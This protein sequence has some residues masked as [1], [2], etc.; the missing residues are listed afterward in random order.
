MKSFR[1]YI[2]F[3]IIAFL[4]EIIVFNPF[5]FLNLS[6]KGSS[7]SI[8]GNFSI[9]SGQS[10][11]SASLSDCNINCE[12]IY[13]DLS[14]VMENGEQSPVDVTV[15]L[16]DDGNSIPYTLS[17][18][19]IFPGIKKERYLTI[20]PYGNVHSLDISIASQY[21][22]S[23]QVNDVVVNPRT[24]LFFRLPRFLFVALLL[25]LTDLFLLKNPIWKKEWSKSEAIISTAIVLFI[26]I[27]F[28][29]VLARMGKAFL[30]P[31][32]DYHFQY[33][34][35]ARAI[36]E[37]KLYIN[38]DYTDI[39]VS[40]QSIPNPY[41]TVMRSSLADVSNCWDIAYFNGHFYVYFGV[42][43]VF[44][45][46]LPYYLIFHKDFPTWFGV[47]ISASMALC[48]SFYLFYVI[49]KK[50]FASLS[51][52]QY[53]VLSI[54]L[55]NS[56]NLFV[57][58][59]HADFYYL[60]IVT[61]LAFVL[62][63]LGLIMHATYFNN[64]KVVVRGLRYALGSLLIALTAG[65]RPQFLIS[66]FLMVIILLTTSKFKDFKKYLPNIIIPM[67]IVAALLMIYNYA[68]FS[69]P[70]DFGANYNLTTND[71]RYRG[72]NLPRGL[73]GLFYYYI[74]PINSSVIFPFA[75]FTIHFSE[76]MGLQIS[77]WTYGGAFFLY[78]VLLSIPGMVL[79]RKDLKSKKIIPALVS[80]LI[81]SVVVVIAD[82]EMAG[83]LTRYY[84]DFLW[85]LAIPAFAVLAQ[86]LV[87]VKDK[88]IA[89][90]LY[91][92]ILFAGVF[93]LFYE[94]L[95]AIKGSGM[96][97]DNPAVYYL[98]RSFM[99]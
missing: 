30:H 49:K 73:E 90:L 99:V 19:R 15:T 41:D 85:L 62:W 40:L 32:W 81:L 38:E 66:I 87:N 57:C 37:G 97:D 77:D 39:I 89:Q 59:L 11:A 84:V 20:H 98:L 95:V 88:Q 35:L 14:A 23:V 12:T 92:F 24:P 46:Y 80:C 83:V 71:M 52:F 96:L 28:F 63:G 56:L 74:Q 70:F 13:L 78:P 45:Y 7:L 60:P 42:V 16:T 17:A 26:N 79:V 86:L 34:K 1:K 44:I 53:L 76:Y 69:S 22:A 29:F 51:H 8:L 4:I 10:V 36:M 55:G 48:G 64:E 47:F 9:D 25:C 27:V 21:P 31:V 2:L 43:P 5:C 18:K 3:I 82:T 33:Q 94:F 6:H 68:R 58:M 75:Q 67:V 93:G 61:S 91:F 65:C 54:I 50:F 72:F